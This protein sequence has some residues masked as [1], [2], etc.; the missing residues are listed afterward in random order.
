MRCA[1]GQHIDG[2]VSVRT[3][4]A[5][6]RGHVWLSIDPLSA[7]RFAAYAQ[8]SAWTHDMSDDK[9]SK[10]PPAFQKQVDQMRAVGALSPYLDLLSRFGV[11]GQ[12]VKDFQAGLKGLT[13]QV[14]ELA[15]LPA[16][17]NDA[18]AERG[19]LISESTSLEAAKA[20]IAAAEGGNVD[21]AEDILAGCYEG[22][23]LMH[24]G[25]ILRHTVAFR[26]RVDLIHEAVLL[27]NAERYLAAVPLLLIVADGVGQDYF[28]KSIFSQG[29]DLTELNALAGHKD[30]L[31]KLI[32]AMCR[33]RQGLTDEPLTFPY[34][35]GI[36]HGRDLGFGNRLVTAKCWSVLSNIADVIRAR[37]AAK[38]LKL[39]P[40]LSLEESLT[41]L[42]KTHEWGA[43][44]DRWK[45]RPV[46]DQRVDA[47]TCDD[48]TFI[49]GEPERVLVRFLRAWAAKNY[50]EMGRLTLYYDGR[51]VNKRAGEIR[52]DMD[53]FEL[54][55]ATILNIRDTAAAGTDIDTEL[56]FRVRGED[57][58][59]NFTF[60]LVC[61]ADGGETRIRSDADARWEVFPRYQGWAIGQRFGRDAR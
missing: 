41:Q 42:Q 16:K 11:G 21:Q 60:R 38:S 9:K 44:V 61:V 57:R 37:E 30:A 52:C 59:D 29:V 23:R 32:Q 26:E 7:N 51:P 43:Q 17:F 33:T 40:E 47:L 48:T 24:V 1:V 3:E 34:R 4:S 35:N 31:P 39:K 50:G 5:S 8:R 36:M 49:E 19:W 27:T 6:V 56:R 18:F 14:E 25:M 45:P 20:A 13:D 22:D 54:A 53:G 55:G 12:A 15:S 58:Q 2:C 10:L 28:K 46:E